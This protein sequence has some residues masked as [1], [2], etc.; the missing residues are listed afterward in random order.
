[1]KFSGAQLKWFAFVLMVAEHFGTWVPVLPEELSFALKILGRLVAP[2]FAF[3]VVEG[4]RHTRNRPRYLLR[5][6]GAG[7]VMALGTQLLGGY[8]TSSYPG[9][10]WLTYN[11][12]L[13]LAFGIS[14]VGCLEVLGNRRLF[15]FPWIGAGLLIP[16]LLVGSAASEGSFLMLGIL[17]AFGLLAPHRPAQLVGF[18]LTSVVSVL[19]LQYPL[20]QLCMLAAI[21]P[22]AL[23]SGEAGNRRGAWVFYVGYPLHLWVFWWAGALV[24]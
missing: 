19:L 12:F 20:W 17:L 9:T 15:S 23:Y 22:L 21:V 4:W 14:V 5:L 11:I 10:P 6:Y 2:I 3:L 18:S 13:S 1:M 24:R 8:L 7:I 16:F